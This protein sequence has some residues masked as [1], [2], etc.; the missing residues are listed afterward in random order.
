MD[1]EEKYKEALERARQIQNTPYTAHWD[2]MKELVEDLFPELAESENERIRKHLI[3]VVELYYGN[4]DEQEKK[5]C[6][7]W[8]ESQG[9]QNLANSE[10]TCKDEQKPADL[11]TKAGNWYVC[12]MEV[13]NENMVTAFHRDEIYYCPKDGYIDVCGALCEVGCL[14]VFR[15]A[16]EKEIPQPKQEWSEEDESHIRY[17]IE[18][19]EHCKKGVSLTMTTPTAQEYIDWLKSLRPQN[20]TK[21]DKERYISCLQRLGTGNPEQPE[22]INSKW[23]K[24]H[25][26]PQNRW[27][28][29]AT[30]IKVLEDV[31][32]RGINP[33]NYH[34]TLH[35]ILELL[36]KLREEWL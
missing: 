33:I 30:D 26:Y 1:Y 31:I 10:K 18:C 27:K 29:S 20:W 9:E 11:K 35:G 5:D 4:T 36:K 17:L 28:P 8:L 23:F 24:E 6:I 7:A 19:L 22:T 25:V 3:G 16:T 34:A 15:L 14:D 12:D 2:V 13:M 21:E 32:D